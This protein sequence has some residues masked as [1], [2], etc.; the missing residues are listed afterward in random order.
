MKLFYALKHRPF[1]LIWAG[2]TLSRFGDNLYQ[3]G[4][5]WWVLETT[6]S[7]AAMGT[8]LILSMV[9]SLLLLLIGGVL[10]DRW[11]R[12]QVMLLSDGL[13]GG[14]LGILALLAWGQRLDLWHIYLGSILLGMTSAFFRPAYVAL[15]PEVTPREILP[16]ANALTELGGQLTGILGPALAAL[17]VAQGGVTTAFFL[18]SLT[19]WVAALC[20]VPLRRFPGPSRQAAQSRNILGD[21]GEGLAVVGGTGWLWGTILMLSLINLTGRSPMNVSLPF[22]VKDN[23]GAGVDTLGLLLSLFSIG[24]VLGTIWLGHQTGLRRRGRVIYFALVV[25]GLVTALLGLPL[26]L[27]GLGLA[28]LL[29]GLALAVVN[30]TWTNLLQETIPS[31]V[32]GRVASLQTLGIEL[33]LPL[34]FALAGWATDS[35]G[36]ATVFIS[37]GLLTALIAGLALLHPAIR[38]L[39]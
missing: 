19:F 14:L 23:I 25:V 18:D 5:A 36:A 20:L 34:G 37:G 6:G 7:A 31:A 38:T 17:L 24:S 16:S 39:D 15:I 11:P 3:V 28:M 29:L 22:L 26:P 21:I 9:P 12:I 32:F 8:V 27:P 2:Q 35:F 1:A 33:I 30:L 4:L 13:R 10:V